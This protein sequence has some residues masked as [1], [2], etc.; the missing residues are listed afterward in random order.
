[1]TTSDGKLNI[2]L[3]SIHGQKC[4]SECTKTPFQV[5]NSF[6]QTLPNGDEYIPTP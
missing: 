1:M 6:V 2:F 3:A 4:R 5:K